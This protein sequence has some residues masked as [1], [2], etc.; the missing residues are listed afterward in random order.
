[1]E[2]KKMTWDKHR[3]AEMLNLFVWGLLKQEWKS[4]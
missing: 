2:E 3:K 1:M 4:I